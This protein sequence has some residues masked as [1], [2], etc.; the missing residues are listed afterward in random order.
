MSAC[1]DSFRVVDLFVVKT[2]C[3]LTCEGT[4]ALGEE[5]GEHE[6]AA[7]EHG[8]HDPG[9]TRLPSLQCASVHPDH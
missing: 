8:D 2:C 5:V 6:G 9:D 4:E 3:I 7:H 1:P